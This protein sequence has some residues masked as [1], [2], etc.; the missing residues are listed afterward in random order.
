[1]T[2]EE[3]ARRAET[4]VICLNGITLHQIVDPDFDVAIHARGLLADAVA[5]V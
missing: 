4:L 1:M 2:A 5:G 3:L